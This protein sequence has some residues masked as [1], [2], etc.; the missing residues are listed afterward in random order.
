MKI[1]MWIADKTKNDLMLAAGMRPIYQLF[2]EPKPIL[3]SIEDT[4]PAET[5][6]E[7]ILERGKDTIIAGV[8]IANRMFWRTG[9]KVVGYKGREIFIS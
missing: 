8:Y 2:L 3:A 1:G 4:R 7:D 5:I 9:L 6:A